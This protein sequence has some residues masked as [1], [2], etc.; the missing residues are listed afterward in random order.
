MLYA[1]MLK[2]GRHAEYLLC[3]KS[4]PTKSVLLS[5]LDDHGSIMESV[6]VQHILNSSDCEDNYPFT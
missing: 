3:P 6:E 4:T 2:A 5:A 1:S